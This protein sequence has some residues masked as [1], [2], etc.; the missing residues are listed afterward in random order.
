MQMLIKLEV[1][2]EETW[3][4]ILKLR[5]PEWIHIDASLVLRL[6]FSHSLLLDSFALYSPHLR[7]SEDVPVN[8]LLNDCQAEFQLMLLLERVLACFDCSDNLFFNSK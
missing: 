8:V 1:T 2:L 7:N 3:V 5:H 6:F 4:S